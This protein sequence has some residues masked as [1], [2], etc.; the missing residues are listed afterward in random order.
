MA[1][2]QDFAVQ[3]LSNGNIQQATRWNVQGQWWTR[4]AQGAMEMVANYTPAGSGAI[5]FA[6]KTN[7]GSD[8]TEDQKREIIDTLADMLMRFRAESDG[9]PL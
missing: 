6:F 3:R 8:L 5:L 7:I 4:N 9:V 2:L 1:D